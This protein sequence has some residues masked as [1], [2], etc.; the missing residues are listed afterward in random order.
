MVEIVHGSEFPNGTTFELFRED[1]CFRCKKHKD[2]EDGLVCAFPGDGGCPIEDAMERA[3]W[4]EPF[5][6]DDIVSI[7]WDGHIRYWHV[8]KEFESDNADLQ[9]A[10]LKLFEG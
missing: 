10:Y 2:G 1:F 3:A 6:G 9:R 7:A 8:C 4:G 5:P